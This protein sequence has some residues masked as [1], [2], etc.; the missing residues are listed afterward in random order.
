VIQAT[1]ER[2][3]S[4]HTADGETT[5]AISL[6]DLIAAN[7]YLNAPTA[8]PRNALSIAKFCPGSPVD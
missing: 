5:T 7:D 1:A 6:K 2:G 8:T 3:V 4:S